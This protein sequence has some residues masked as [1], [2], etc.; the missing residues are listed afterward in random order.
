ME[1]R[2]D[3]ILLYIVRDEQR[4]VLYVSEGKRGYIPVFRRWETA[5]ELAG[6]MERKFGAPLGFA[7]LAQVTQDSLEDSYIKALPK[8][9]K[10]SFV[11]EGTREFQALE[12]KVRK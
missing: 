11:Y 2:L 5:R 10:Y 8:G 4:L 6:L 1:R 7:A 12:R 3:V 9:L